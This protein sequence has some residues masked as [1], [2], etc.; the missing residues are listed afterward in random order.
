MNIFK[1][2]GNGWNL[3]MTS[4]KII[5]EN[6]SLIL[7]PIVSMLALLLVMAT[8]FGGILASYGFDLDGFFQQLGGNN[9]MVIYGILFLYYLVNYF[10]IIFFNMGLVHCVRL[11][12]EGKPAAFSDGINFSSSRF[13]AIL[14]WALLAATV[15]VILK[16]VEERMGWIGQII[17]GI[18][19]AVWSIATFFVVPVIAYENV[20][21]V[22]AVKR[23]GLMMKEKWGESIGANFSFGLFFLIGYSIIMVGGIAL[24]QVHPIVGIVAMV[25]SAIILHALVSAGKMVFIAA[26][27]NHMVDQ[28]AS[29]FEESG[30]LDHLFIEKRKK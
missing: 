17:S 12:F 28:P 3:G 21:P 30:V 9:E 6:R 4:L 27:Y 18:L 16:V 5:K 7:F 24:M 13:N 1:R 14:Q 20:S 15:G 11:I 29:Y 19:G 22:E 26:T 10:V 25:L 23:S 8:F 2:M